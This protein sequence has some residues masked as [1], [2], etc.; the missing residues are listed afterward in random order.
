MTSKTDLTGGAHGVG[1]D[2]NSLGF[3]EKITNSKFIN[4]KTYRTGVAQ[5]SNNYH[6]SAGGLDNYNY[7]GEISNTLFEY[8]YTPN[9]TMSIIRGKFEF[10]KLLITVIF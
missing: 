1:I 7:I 2:N 8:T 10:I 4:N 5:S 6:A 3:I 9:E